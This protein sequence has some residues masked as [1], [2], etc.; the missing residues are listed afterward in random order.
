MSRSSHRMFSVE[1]DHRACNFIKK[2]LQ[3][4]C[5]RKKFAKFLKISTLKNIWKQLL[6]YFHYIYHY[7]Y[8]HFHY[9]CKMH[10][11]R[12]WTLLIIPLDCDMTHCLFKLNFVAFFPH[13]FFY[14]FIP[15]FISFI[16]PSERNQ[17]GSKGVVWNNQANFRI[18][19]YT[20]I[21]IES[22]LPFLIYTFLI[23]LIY[24]YLFILTFSL[25]FYLNLIK[26]L[27]YGG[28]YRNYVKIY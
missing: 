6:L 11:H 7:H 14:S 24:I 27:K 16:T 26:L 28:K 1:K 2:K 22:Y 10:L 20:Y 4:R 18:S 17:K 5:F 8:H 9:H 21:Y 12:L 23:M 19:L 13:I 25:Y 15:R 3:H